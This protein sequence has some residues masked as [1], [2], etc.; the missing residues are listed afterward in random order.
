MF[1]LHLAISPSY[2]THLHTTQTCACC[3]RTCSKVNDANGLSG[4]QGRRPAHT[5]R[6][7]AAADGGSHCR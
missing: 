3:L 1:I 6:L 4:T 5:A 2:I 7:E